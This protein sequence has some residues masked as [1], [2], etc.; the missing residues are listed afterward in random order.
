MRGPIESFKTERSRVLRWVVVGATI[1]SVGVVFLPRAAQAVATS[2]DYIVVLRDGVNLSKKVASEEKRGNDVGDTF[3]AGSD[4]FV[5]SLDSSDVA[6]LRKDHDVRIIERDAPVSLVADNETDTISS[7]STPTGAV[8]EVIPGRYIVRYKSNDALLASVNSLEISVLANYT[9]VFPGYVANLSDATAN[10]L[11]T[12]Q[13]VVLVEQD[14]VVSINT[15]QPIG[16]GDSWGLDRVDQRLLP[17]NMMYSYSTNGTGVSAYIIDT[18]IRAT[19]VELAGRVGSGFTAV[20]DGNGSSDCHGHGTHVSGTVGGTRYG[21]A[22]NVNFFPVRVL[23]C[24][25][26]GSLSGVIAGIDWVIANHAAGVP[27]VANM[28]LGG[29]Y[30]SSLNAA[31]ARGV[32]DGVVFAV[33][34]GNESSLACNVSPASEP[35]AITVGATDTSDARAYFSNYG[36]CVDIFAPGVGI[37]SSTASSDTSTASWSGTS[38]A[39]PHVAGVAAQYLQSHP[40]DTPAQVAR[41]LDAAT[42]SNVIVNPGTGSPNKLLYN[43]SFYPAPITV[44]SAPNSL[45]SVAGSSLVTL[46]WGAPLTDGGVAISNYVVEY[47]SASGS[48]TTFAHPASTALSIIVTGLTNATAYSFRVSATNSVGTSVS[49]A[50]T[51]VTPRDPTLP[52]A[53]TAVSAIAGNA[54]AVV[55]WTAPSSATISS[56]TINSTT[57][58]VDIPLTAGA[59]DVIGHS[60]HSCSAHVASAIDPWLD[61]IQVSTGRIIFSNDDGAHNYSTDCYASRITTTISGSGYVLRVRGCCGHPYGVVRLEQRST[62]VDVTGYTVKSSPAGLTCTTATLSCTVAGL[63]NGTPYTFTVIATNAVGNSVSSSPSGAVTPTNPALPSAPTAVSA[64]AGNASA[65]VRWTAPVISSP[66]WQREAGSIQATEVDLDAPYDSGY[67]IRQWADCACA[68]FRWVSLTR[69]SDVYDTDIV[70]VDAKWPVTGYTVKSSPAGLTCT[71]AT[72]SCTVA[73][74]TNGTPYTFTVIATNA[75]GNSVSSSPSGAVTPT[76]PVPSAPTAVSAT[77]GNASAVVRWTAPVSSFVTGYTVKSSPAGLTCT[78][79]ILSC[80]VAGLTN[81]TSYTFTVIATNA[82]GNSVSSSPSGAVI[83]L[84]Y[85]PG[86]VVAASWGLDRIDQRALPL[87]GRI[88]RAG[89]GAGVTAYVIDTGIYAGHSEFGARVR[90]GF[91]A[92]NDGNGTQDCQGHG[93]HVSGTVGGTTYGVAPLVTLVPVRVLDCNG[94]GSVSGVIAG[95][96]FMIQDHATGVP[97]VA[98]MSLGVAGVSAALNDAVA[99]AIADGITVVVA[100]GN[101]YADACGSSPASAPLAVTVG[102]TTSSDSMSY[103]SNYGSC[104][105]IFAP[106]SSITS[107]AISSSSATTTMSGT[108]MASP[109]VAGVAAV[110]LGTQ[111]LL[112]PAEVATAMK[113]AAT[114]GVI[115]SIGADSPNLLLF[116]RVASTTVAPVT[117]P[118]V[119]PVTPPTTVAPVTPPTTV[120][121]VTPPTT[122]APVTPPTTVAPVTPPTAVAVDSA[123]QITTVSNVGRNVTITVNSPAGAL[124]TI[125]RDGKVVA[126]GK[127][128]VFTLKNVARGNHSFQAKVKVGK[129]TLKSQVVNFSVSTKR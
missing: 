115:T 1:A 12:T 36:A 127:S 50:T 52:S 4:G 61:V 90:S 49:S 2:S 39:T 95:I 78:T 98:N 72:L 88:T 22:K 110:I 102:A 66:R 34:A 120:A 14:K 74:L 38:M 51:T 37:K 31:V 63:T 94:S 33:A 86:D 93:T 107:A 23:D 118:T 55:R 25:G 105:D 111:N 18:G 45:T 121:P 85:V 76:E 32:A 92:I 100:A 67:S 109:H 108:S 73:G 103:F 79:A 57:P 69:I 83:P 59:L 77:A 17:M 71:T 6:R 3:S 13:G 7:L 27:A 19:H 10:Q 15:D 46:S 42:T 96:D 125:I 97:A 20:N 112:T 123:L 28:S 65:V 114:T 60:D 47:S 81:G 41:A 104:V 126:K 106:G 122:V 80:T 29:G 5:A 30:S 89:S 26:S 129:R 116:S 44:P 8:G 117:P 128:S 11:R 43:V 9:N 21:I 91:N 53:P 58:Y 16:V 124:V 68:R 84:T 70:L 119:A 48:W 54:S 82:V 75:V 101:S 40:T 99:R 113:A 62:V 64:T 24:N 35:T 56:I 87:N